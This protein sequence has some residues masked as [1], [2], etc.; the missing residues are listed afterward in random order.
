MMCLTGG[1]VFAYSNLPDQVKIGLYYSGAALSEPKISCDG[2]VTVKVNGEEVAWGKNL[3]IKTEDG[4]TNIYNDDGLI[5]TLAGNE[6]IEYYPT[7]KGY[8]RSEGRE[9]RGFLFTIRLDDGKYTVVNQVNF[10]EYLYG[11]VPK[12]LSA[13]YP[14]EALKAQAICAR[15]YAANSIGNYNKQGFDM[16]GD[17]NSQAYGGVAVETANTTRAVNETK[18]SIVTY[19]GKPA[20]VFYF[21]TSGGYTLNS[22]DVWLT[23]LPYLRSVEDKYQE[24]VKPD[25]GAWNLTVTA[26]R[27]KEI[28]ANKGVDIGDITDLQTEINPQGAVTKLT[29]VGTNGTKTY[30][31]EMT[32]NVL[33][34]KSQVY[35]VTANR[36]KGEEVTNSIYALTANGIEKIT[37]DFI[38]RGNDSY[39]NGY[40]YAAKTSDATETITAKT[41]TVPDTSSEGLTFTLSGYG[42]GHGVGMSQYG[43]VGMAYKGF[44]STDILT[45]YFQGTTIE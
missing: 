45:Y 31:K 28:L 22:K 8:I 4:V 23:D 5:Y 19:G 29:F 6:N 9:Y 11:V 36:P 24:S 10:E 30:E 15:T 44:S 2:Y 41:E 20:Q 14:I 42:W 3:V 7:E 34:L 40:T 13:S 38:V 27:F 12:E 21:S 37:N 17:Q 25:K 16:T 18:G 35:T 39:N 26:E 33:G 32:R 1:S 43:A